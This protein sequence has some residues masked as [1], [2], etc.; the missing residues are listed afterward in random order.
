MKA[1]REQ[2]KAKAL[3]LMKKLGMDE[4]FIEGLE[5]SP[6]FVP[7]FFSAVWD[8][9]KVKAIV[10]RLENERGIFVYYVT[11]EETSF[12]ECYSFLCVSNYLEDFPRQD[13]RE[14]ANGDKLVYAWVE[15]ISRPAHSE[16]GSI[17]VSNECGVLVR[18]G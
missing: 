3:E 4:L 10:E 1:T 6:N 15:N 5:K 9:V 2:Q 11:H 7:E 13:I 14:C 16:Y 12:G 8:D 17:V 18:V